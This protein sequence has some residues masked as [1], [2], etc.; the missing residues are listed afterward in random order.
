MCVLRGHPVARIDH[1]QRD[2]RALN[3]AQRPQHAVLLDLAVCDVPTPSDAR[4]IDERHRLVFPQQMRVEHVP[5]GAGDVADDGPFLTDQR[6]EQRGFT[7]VW[8]ADNGQAQLVALHLD[9]LRWDAL[10]HLVKQIANAV[11]V[12]GRHDEGLA[13]PE[14][15]ELDGVQL[16]FQVIGLIGR[17]DHRFTAVS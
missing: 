16:T 13:Q 12:H 15:I 5:C 17:E 1:Q 6:V 7:D 10:D 4:R 2:V 11:A 8:P 14:L 3:R 9:W